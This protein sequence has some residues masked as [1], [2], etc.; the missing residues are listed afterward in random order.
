LFINAVKSNICLHGGEF[1]LSHRLR[2]LE[3]RVQRNVLGSKKVGL[4]R[5][6]RRRHKEEL[7]AVCSTVNTVWVVKS[8]RIR[9]AG[10]VARTGKGRGL[11]WV[12]VGKAEARRPLGIPRR[13]WE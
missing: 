4:T 9:W 10:N 11:Y 12:L 2:A 7:T 5:Y 13:R 8:R 6:W 3:N 1:G